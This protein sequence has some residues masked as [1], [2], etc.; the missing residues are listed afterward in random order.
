MPLQKF[1]ASNLDPFTWPNGAIG[2][3]PGGPF[4][5]LG[6]YAKVKACPIA[7]T[8]L[9]RTVYATGYPDTFFSIP[10]CT[11]VRG[12]YI[13]GFLTVDDR[14]TYNGVVFHP[15]DRYR[16]RIPSWFARSETSSN[17]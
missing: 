16:D 1:Y 6:P 7:G 13:G 2:H 12:R 15:Y 11:R 3:R 14:G 4:D 5:C 10:A 17:G 9:R 8:T